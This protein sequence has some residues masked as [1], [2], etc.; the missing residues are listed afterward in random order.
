M[1]GLVEGGG[2]CY[3]FLATF[4][5]SFLLQPPV[6]ADVHSFKKKGAEK[7]NSVSELVSQCDNTIK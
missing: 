1:V 6:L 2:S 3:S 5:P 4:H 7:S